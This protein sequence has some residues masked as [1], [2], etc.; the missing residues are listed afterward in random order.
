MEKL[1][2]QG[3]GSELERAVKDDTYLDKLLEEARQGAG[4]SEE[5]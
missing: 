5:D 2:A 4:L 3:R 1:F